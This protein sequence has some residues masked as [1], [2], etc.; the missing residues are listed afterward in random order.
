MPEEVLHIF[1]NR[2]H[3]CEK[4]WQSKESLH[5][6]AENKSK[7]LIDTCRTFTS[8]KHSQ[9]SSHLITLHIQKY[10]S[11]E[12]VQKSDSL[13]IVSWKKNCSCFLW[14]NLTY[15]KCIFIAHYN[16]YF[17]DEHTINTIRS[18]EYVSRYFTDILMTSKG[19]AC[20]LNIYDFTYWLKLYLCCYGDSKP[21]FF[22]ALAEVAQENI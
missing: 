4:M 2:L 12:F 8:V 7:T 15:E 1:W 10:R 11:I 20:L 17:K 3:W 16:A 19:H 22:F 9:H 6:Q 5:T 21:I 13:S 14:W 18:W